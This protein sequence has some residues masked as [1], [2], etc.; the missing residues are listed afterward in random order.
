MEHPKHKNGKDSGD[1][2]VCGHSKHSHKHGKCQTC[3]YL[4]MRCEAFWSQSEFE[5]WETRLSGRPEMTDRETVE[6]RQ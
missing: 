1:V 2:C 6:A 3:D 4:G 5:E